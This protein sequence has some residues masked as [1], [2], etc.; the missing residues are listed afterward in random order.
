MN[1]L[2]AL[3]KEIELASKKY[4]QEDS[5]LLTDGE[6][7]SLV[8][9][10]KKLKKENP[11]LVA[12]NDPMIDIGS[13]PLS[14]FAKVKH[15]VPLLSL[16]NAFNQDDVIRF[17]E[18][19]KRFL[20]LGSSHKLDYLAEPKID[21]LSLAL[22]YIN[23]KLFTAATRGDGKIGEDVTRNA[24]TIRDIPTT[25]S[26][27]PEI[28]EVRGEVYILKSDFNKFNEFQRSKKEK[29]FANA[30]NAAAGSLRQLNSEVTKNRPL[31]FFAYSLGTISYNLVPS[32]EQL[33]KVLSNFGFTVN[34]DRHSCR[35]VNQLLQTYEH[36]CNKRESLDYE[37]DGI[38]YKVNNFS[39]QERLGARS[40]SPRWA[41][42]HKF[43]AEESFTKLLSIEIQVGRTGTLSPVAK[44]EPV[45]I[46]GVMVSSATLHNEDFI[47]G[48][49][50]AG[51]RIRD[52]I[53]IR[54]GD[55]VSVYR[56]G[57]VIPKVKSINLAERKIDSKPFIFPNCCPECGGELTKQQNESVIRCD[58]GLSCR[59]QVLER[60]KHFVS[61]QGCSIEGLGE[62]QIICF[63]DLGWLSTP[64]D[65]FRLKSNHGKNSVRPLE[66]LANWGKK[67]AENLFDSID[68]SRDLGLERFINALGIRYVGEV[69][70]LT[71]ARYYET[72]PVFHKKMLNIARGKTDDF[73]ELTN[74]DGIGLKSAEELRIY[75]ESKETEK[76]VEELLL[77]I[78]ITKSV[79]R[80]VLSPVSGLTVVF[81][82]SLEAMSRS[83]AKSFAEKMGAK[84][85]NT[86]SSK[87]SILI[88]GSG[89]G[90]KLRKAK[91][92]GIKVLTENEWIKLVK[93]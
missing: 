15:D 21:G 43:P 60:M 82:G 87:T 91:K 57:D 70:S 48:F 29:I 23:G 74:I 11:D 86:I 55:L 20:G 64:V 13:P 49:D 5:P 59:A 39:Y 4:F 63:Y 7:D 89:A 16:S 78:N 12:D 14:A 33:M 27:A 17:D 44:L 24:I 51:N 83:E 71:L 67:S 81:T 46:G 45:E 9:R 25:I 66:K 84:V 65:I 80:T 41:I 90:S 2:T 73:E 75:F 26:N 19:V 31:R 10:Y 79:S 37:V 69:V 61:K 35:G 93:S 30:R 92:I 52:G 47:K 6:F 1:K 42:A 18:S 32:Q 68:D 56:A 76:L 54:V 58:A 88:C 77:E 85:S 50:N 53:D 36:I 8:A 38:V 28:L 22:K 3:A 40:N 62:K 72:W 34:A